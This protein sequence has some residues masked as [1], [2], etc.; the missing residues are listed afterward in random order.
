MSRRL[1]PCA[2]AAISGD[3]RS[4]SEHHI[5]EPESQ[6]AGPASQQLGAITAASCPPAESSSRGAANTC[7]IPCLL[8]VKQR[9]RPCASKE[10]KK[11]NLRVVFMYI[12]FHMR[13]TGGLECMQRLRKHLPGAWLFTIAREGEGAFLRHVRRPGATTRQT[14]L[15]RF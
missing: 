4:S 13:T 9:C 1:A 10:R 14:R 11:P 2:A 5:Q 12:M 8:W 3:T 7:T 15:R 6:T